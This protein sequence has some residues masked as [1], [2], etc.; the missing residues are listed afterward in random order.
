MRR[1]R[2]A[3]HF[4]LSPLS[5][6]LPFP[7]A[8]IG[9]C[10]LLAVAAAAQSSLDTLLGQART[11]EKAGDY[12]GAARIYQQALALAPGNL[13]VLKRFG[14]LEQTELKFDNS[15]ARFR[16]VLAVNP[17]YPEVNF[18]LG[19]S[20]FGRSD[21]RGAIESFQRELAT[22]KAQPRCRYYL[23]LALQSSGRT[24]DAITELNHALA[25]GPLRCRL[26]L[27]A[28]PATQERLAAS[29]RAVEGYRPGLVPVTRS[30]GRVLC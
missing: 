26:A 15:I 3:F 4:E 1:Q 25:D 12:L 2:S 22:P 19:V 16:Q 13:E 14:I 18:Y 9:A 29:N 6:S 27:S 28:R 23:A 10:V 5:R 24:D 7:A 8:L 17:E 30:H 20:Y 21:F 11:E